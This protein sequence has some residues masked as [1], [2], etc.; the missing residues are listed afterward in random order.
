MR[1]IG[2]FSPGHTTVAPELPTAREQGYDIE[3]S[4]LRGLPADIRERLVKAV[5]QAANDPEFKEK[6]TGV[7]DP[8]RYL[9][10]ADFDRVIKEAEVG[11]RQLWKELP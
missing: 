8:L 2:Q 10:P 9:S 5:A 11:F 3:L 6:A 1:N 4:S 7:F